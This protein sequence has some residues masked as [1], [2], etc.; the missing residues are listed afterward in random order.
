MIGAAFAPFNSAGWVFLVVVAAFAASVA[1][2]QV[3]KVALIVGGVITIALIEQLVLRLPWSFLA[4]VAGCGI[5]T[6]IMTT[7][8]LRRSMAVR[9]LARH[10]ERERIARDMHDVLGHTL[11]V[12]I[13]KTDLAARLAHRD[14]DRTV[15]ELS[16]VDRIARE[17]L[18]EVRE[19]IRGYRAKSLEHEIELARHTLTIAGIGVNT[20]F[21][22]PRLDPAQENVLCLALRE[23]VTNIVRHARARHCR[24][25]VTVQ[26]GNCVLEIADDGEGAS[27]TETRG[28]HQEGAGLSGMRERVV[29]G[30]GSITHCVDR[31][32]KLTIRL[33]WVVAP[34]GTGSGGH[35][36]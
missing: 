23:A 25:A 16:E 35:T 30:G 9:E 13:L 7:L 6:A 1:V 33:P 5:P 24:L 27:P 31:G 22:P 21:K 36:P 18:D 29:A 26:D 20:E 14:P 11:S 4:A 2:G 8:T 28:K 15:R 10:G 32:T 34:N 3:R 19:T 17:T 12:I